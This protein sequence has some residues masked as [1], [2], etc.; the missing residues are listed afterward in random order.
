MKYTLYVIRFLLAL[1]FIYAAIDKIIN[2]VLPKDEIGISTEF[3]AFYSLLL[4]SKFMYFV[5][6][7]QFICGFLLLFNR[8]YLLGAIMFVPL[9]LCLIMVHVFISNSSFYILFDSSLFLMNSILIVYRF[10]KIKPIFINSNIPPK[11]KAQ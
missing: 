1:L 8:T 7:C 9:L 11:T 3:I 6:A 5:C 2:P 10:K 4:E